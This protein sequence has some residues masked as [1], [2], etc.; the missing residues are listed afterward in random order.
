MVASGAEC[1]THTIAYK[2]PSKNSTISSRSVTV[3]HS[4]LNLGSKVFAGVE[5]GSGFLVE[6]HYQLPMVALTTLYEN[7]NVSQQFAPPVFGSPAPNTPQNVAQ[8]TN[9]FNDNLSGLGFRLGYR[10]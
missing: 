10:F 5:I 1:T 2:S 3:E 6:L 4:R 8:G 9:R 7:E